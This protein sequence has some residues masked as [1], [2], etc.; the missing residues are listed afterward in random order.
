MDWMIEVERLVKSF[1]PLTAVD[2]VSF[3]VPRGQVLGFLG[4]NGAG[5][6]TTM[7]MITGFLNPTA[8]S[9]RVCGQDVVEQ[10]IQAKARIG[11]L[12]EGAPAYPDMT[13]IRFLNFIADVRGLAGEERRRRLDYVID[14]VHLDD[15][16]EQPI[17]T[18]SKGFKRRVGLA[19]AILHNPPVLILDEPTD[20]LDPNQKHEVRGLIAEMAKEKAIV[21]STH[22]LEEVDAVCT[23]AMII[24]DGRIVADGTPEELESRSPYHNAVLIDARADGVSADLQNLDGVDRVEELGDGRYRIY[25][26]VGRSILAEVSDLARQKA[27]NVSRLTVE[28]PRLDEVFRR[29][30]QAGGDGREAA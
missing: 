20:G 16:L 28:T 15:V 9:V 2:D 12:P 24:A 30:T 13:P 7:K 14:N 10:P 1:G 25:P 3:K 5:K 22:I 26:A 4:P 19:Q 6:S 17:D 21:I 8:G 29:I 11:Y 23:R 18:L 27:W